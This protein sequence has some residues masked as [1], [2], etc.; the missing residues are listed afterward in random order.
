L[1]PS[2]H[3]SAFFRFKITMTKQ[4]IVAK[5]MIVERIPIRIDAIPAFVTYASMYFFPIN[6]PHAHTQKKK[7]AYSHGTRP[8]VTNMIATEL[9]VNNIIVAVVADDTRGWI[10]MTNIVGPRIIPPPTPIRPATMPARN[11]KEA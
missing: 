3:Q 9:L 1:N 2:K 7:T 6:A 11:V 4:P 10:P 8:D 5:P